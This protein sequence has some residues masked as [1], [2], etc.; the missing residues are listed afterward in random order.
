MYADMELWTKI[1]RQV[2]VDGVSKRQVMRET[3]MHWKTLEKILHHSSPP[4]YRRS[5][6]RSEPKIGPFRDRIA[7]IL[8]SDK[9]VHKKQR[10]TAKRIFERIREEGYT[11]GYTQVK[12][13]V[14]ELK[15]RKREV[16]VPLNHPPGEAQMDFG[17]ALAKIDGVLQQ[18]VFFVMSLPYS[19]AVY[20]QAFPR[21][22]TEVLWE[23]HVRS[24]AFFEGVPSRISYDN[25]RTLVAGILSPRKRKLT[26]GFQQLLSHYLFDPHFCLVRRANEKGVVESMVRYTRSNFMVPVPEVRDLDELNAHLE[27][28]CRDELNRKL[29]GKRAAKGELLME[30]QA[31]FRNLPDLPFAACRQRSTAVDSLSLVR[32][33]CNQYSVPVDYAHRT[34]VVKGYCDRVEVGC[35]NETIATHPRLWTRD[36]VRFDPV[37][38]LRLLERKPG[39]LDHARPLSGWEL[40]ES[41]SMLR[42]RLE[43][44]EDGEGTR[45][46]IRVLRLLEKHPMD[47]VER[48]V[49]E[50]LRIHAH[51]RDA[52]A[53]FLYPQE[54]W[55]FTTFRLEGREHLRRV[56]VEV[57]DVSAY[58]ELLAAGGDR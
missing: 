33:D 50:G 27:E 23:G 18:I 47:A 42:R 54:D 29:R 16:F 19:D 14:R 41:F 11:G 32:F 45:E 21:I 35:L 7:Q 44:T 46:Y 1:R 38:Y 49:K 15:G 30:D 25:D 24:F 2:L 43:N 20:V 52:I 26:D 9:E 36:D 58:N 39:A 31:A 55:R 34:V 51:S 57:S 53:Q 37:H 8:D 48:A 40:P 4:G 10:H 13:V 5:Q 6:P 56:K 17:F 3:G 12:E 22:C 28:R